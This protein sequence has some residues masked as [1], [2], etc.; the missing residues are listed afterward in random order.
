MRTSNDHAGLHL[1]LTHL[2]KRSTPFKFYISWLKE[3]EFNNR[4]RAAWK[5]LVSGTPLYKLQSKINAVRAAGI[6]N[7]QN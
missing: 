6:R 4:F 1:Q 2:E 3:E 5:T 7:G